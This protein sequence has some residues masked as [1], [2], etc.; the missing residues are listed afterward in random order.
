MFCAVGPA[1]GEAS[2]PA[3]LTQNTY[4]VP[5]RTSQP[6]DARATPVKSASPLSRVSASL[7]HA[8]RRFFPALTTGFARAGKIRLRRGDST[9]DSRCPRSLGR[10]RPARELVGSQSTTRGTNG[11]SR[12]DPT[13]LELI[14][15]VIE[16][17]IVILGLLTALATYKAA[18]HRGAAGRRKRRG[19]HPRRRRRK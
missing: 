15:K 5:C 9:L 2:A 12:M 18:T 1:P 13:I 10:G 17:L 19:S 16:L 14:T 4:L 8:F 11:G 3:P 6:N 7:R